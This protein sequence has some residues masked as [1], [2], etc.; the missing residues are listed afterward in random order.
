MWL[1]LISHPTRDDETDTYTD[2]QLTDQGNLRLTAHNQVVADRAVRLFGGV[3]DTTEY[4]R[5]AAVLH[6]FGKATPQFQA[7]VRPEETA[8]CPDEETAHA[9]LG[10]LATWYV[11]GELDAPDC[12]RLAATLAVA[13]HHQALPNAAQYTAEPLARAFE[14]QD[15]AIEAQLNA[16]DEEWPEA[17]VE[18]LSETPLS[19]VEWEPFYSWAVSGDIASELREVSTQKTLGGYTPDS[20][21]LPRN[22]YERTLRYWS[23]ITLADKSHAMDI[24]ED[25]IFDLDTLD[26]E[27]IE[28]Y[29]RNLREENPDNDLEARLNDERE[30]ARRQTIRGVH[31]WINN[32]DSQIATLTLPTG[33]GK[34]FTGL[35]A[36]FEARDLLTT[37]EES[38]AR[39]IIYALPYTSIIEQTR[40]LFEDPDLWGADPKQS[41][42]TVHHYLSETVVHHNEYADEDTKATDDNETAELLGEAWRDGTILTTFVQLFESLTG[43]TNRQGLKLSALKS[44]LIIL[45]E[46]QALPKDWWGGVERLLGVLTDE[47]DARIIAMTAT[48]PSLV[49]NLQTESLLAMGQSHDVTTCRA[50]QEGPAYEETL[51]PASRDRY[52]AE[53]ERVRY[54]I[55]STALSRQLGVAETHIG[56]DTAADRIL[57]AT[58]TSGST[59]AVCNTINSSR[60]LTDTLRN[61]P[62][63][64]HLGGE[65]ESILEERNMNAIN[66]DLTPT[67]IA[68]EVVGRLDFNSDAT[69]RNDLAKPSRT[70]GS[71]ADSQTYLLTLNS[72]YRPFDRRI[73]I[74][75]ADRFSTSETPFVLVST[76]AIEAGVDLSF[77]TVFRDIA[78][79][80]SIVQ[81]AGRCNRSYEWGENGGRVIVWMLASPDEET[82]QTPSKKPPAYYVY[83]RGATDAGIPD[84][85]RIISKVLNEIPNPDDATD[86][87]LSRDAVTSY[88]D[89]L[90]SK[91]LWSGDLR[92]AIDQAKA[93][94]LGCQSLISGAQTLDILVALTAAERDEIQ[95]ISDLLMNEDPAGYARL[96]GASAL[97]V[98]LPKSIIEDSPRLSR[99]DNQERDSDGVQ[100]F[101]YAGD[102]DLEYAFATG[103]LKPATESVSNRFT[104]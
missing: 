88:F 55:D 66:S 41:A 97:R 44:S 64:I 22:L 65:I 74:E 38:T 87:T 56:Y 75:L 19:N 90:D 70:R 7:Y 101:R 104:L 81:A 93:R 39:P 20:G 24:P 86:V 48:Q 35:S 54:S 49:R 100:V 94:W 13:R 5:A 6:D 103:G 45:D 63:V 23:A 102:G 14:E 47:F 25:R 8:D 9:R 72:R 84:H 42:L 29:I 15:G 37:D 80:D 73:L 59:L 28:R 62:G 78:P 11:L 18:L 26:R 69:S 30:R 61:R 52:F 27:T 98:S 34:T 3:D 32:G 12:N 2:T 43:P 79:L 36:A 51:S 77:E 68:D 31:K 89:A 46:P 40:E 1:P 67:Q 53:A 57:E 95:Q 92:D 71:T 33:L 85:L 10:A 96:Q 99:I 16:I 17:A 83:E 4:L 82:P 91:S 76:Q 58:D 50:C 21:I 60:E